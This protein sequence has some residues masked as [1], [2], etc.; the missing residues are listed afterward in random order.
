MHNCDLGHDASA[1]FL[2]TVVCVGIVLSYLPQIA[3]I[4]ITGSSIGLSPWFLFLGVTASTSS[5]FNVVTLQWG[6]LR[7]C[8]QLSASR[9]IEHSMGI[10]Q[11]GL[12]WLSFC[13]IFILFLVYY[14]RVFAS[15]R[16][17]RRRGKRAMRKPSAPAK[18]S[19]HLQPPEDADD[20]SSGS[21]NDLE[22][23]STHIF[24]SYGAT[25]A[26]DPVGIRAEAT[27]SAREQDSLL[28]NM[29]ESMRRI[30]D[31]HRLTPDPNVAGTLGSR[32]EWKTAQLLAVIAATHAVI[33]VGTT[34][35]AV[36]GN[37]S[38]RDAHHWAAFL[39][40]TGTILAIGQ[41]LPQIIHTARTRLVQSLSIVTMAV[42]LPGS[43]LFIYTLAGHPGTDWSSLLAYF[44]AAGMQLVL[45]C[46][47]IAWKVR[48]HRE[49][50]DDYGR[51]LALIV[52]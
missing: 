42:Q 30:L 15:P 51:P 28:Q 36:S 47:C 35:W 44:V 10:I 29:P 26:V 3:R 49:Q 43:M 50:I 4:V 21:E 14:P 11:T 34:I 32:D 46:L 13:V 24:Q 39:G 23:V 19:T 2:S 31:Q 7:C 27:H 52:Q 5:F 37:L 17:R 18:P 38:K 33:V 1:F 40:L 41:Y 20:M 9:C 48:Q 22:S 16:Q 6:V 25:S 45:L 8:S 12:Q